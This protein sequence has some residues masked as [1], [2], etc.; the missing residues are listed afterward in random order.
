MG[1]TATNSVNATIRAIDKAGATID[2]ATK[3]AGNDARVNAISFSVSDPTA[4]GGEARA[5]AVAIP[6]IPAPAMTTS[7]TVARCGATTT[8]VA[9]ANGGVAR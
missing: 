4:V 1:Y 5:Q 8:S 2:A 9:V 6:A 7:A 3:A